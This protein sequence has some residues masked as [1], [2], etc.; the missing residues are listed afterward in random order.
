MNKLKFKKSDCVCIT[1]K[2]FKGTATD[3]IGGEETEFDRLTYKID[4]GFL[5]L[6]YHA[7]SCDSSF[8]AK[9]PIVTCP[10]CRRIL[11]AT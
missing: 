1:G 3:I 8:T 6:D 5:C 4:S 9:I 7:Y 2:E 11:G 10:F